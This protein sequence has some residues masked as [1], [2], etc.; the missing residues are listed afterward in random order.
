MT[1]KTNELKKRS[2]AEQRALAAELAAA[3]ADPVERVRRELANCERV[4]E[5]ARQSFL[6]M[7]RG[8]EEIRSGKL[9]EADGYTAFD[10]Y[11]FERWEITA[12]QAYRLIT[13]HRIDLILRPIGHRLQSE[14]AARELIPIS[15]DKPMVLAVY[16]EA[17]RRACGG[18]VTAALVA[19]ARDDLRPPVIEGE[20]ADP[21]S[22]EDSTG[23]VPVDEAPSDSASVSGASTGLGGG[24]SPAIESGQSTPA[25]HPQVPDVPEVFEPTAGVQGQPE[26]DHRGSRPGDEDDV[27]ASS[28][29]RPARSGQEKGADETGPEAAAPRLH[30]GPVDGP[31]QGGT[32]VS[33]PAPASADDPEQVRREMRERMTLRFCESLVGLN[34]IG[35]DPAVWLKEVYLPGIYKM[36]DLPRVRDCF[37]PDSIKAL[38]SVLYQLGDHLQDTGQELL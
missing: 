31:E 38:G 13:S 11:V 23:R 12:R 28:E 7:G 8:L 35:T 24:S 19:A 34:E 2:G 27:S 26:Q 22:P 30:S 33:R 15:G 29:A 5:T 17:V 3:A 16:Q 9:Y 14:A 4:I 37:T 1:P 20:L 36:R 10:E 18:R 21:T 25:D 6:D 32:G